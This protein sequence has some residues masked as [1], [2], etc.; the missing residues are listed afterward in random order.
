MA[1]IRDENPDLLLVI[2]PIPS[3]QL[4]G[5]QPVDEV[6]LEILERLPLT[7]AEG[8]EQEE[9]LYYALAEVA[10]EEGWVF[11]DNLQSL[12]AGVGSGRLFND[13]DYHLLP[14]ASFVIGANEAAVLDPYI[15][16]ETGDTG[17]L[18]H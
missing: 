6:L 10:A 13:F 3:Y 2:S 4:V 16:R 5:E 14:P 11:I 9:R 7:Y 18:P 17:R 1:M 12:R 15:A 8:V